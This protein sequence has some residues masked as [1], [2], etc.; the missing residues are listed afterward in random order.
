MP[1]EQVGLQLEAEGADRYLDVLGRIDAAVATVLSGIPPLVKSIN[2]LDDHFR[3]SAKAILVMG[4]A[5]RDVVG[6]TDRLAGAVADAA[7]GVAKIDDVAGAAQRALD[8]LGDAAATA[9]RD[10][11]GLG[12]DAGKAAGGAADLGKKAGAAGK[13][14]G[15]LGDKSRKAGDDNEDLGKK[16]RKG[17]DGLDV[18]GEAAIGATR[19]LGELATEGLQQIAELAVEGFIS[20]AQAAGD[21][22]QSM[23][24]LAAQSE[25]T[26]G[27]MEAVR[28]TAQA[29]GADLTLPGT[30]ALDAGQAMLELSRG[31]L[32]LKDAMDAAKGTLQLA[33]AAETD[34]ATAAGVATGA[35]AAFGLEGG[36][37]GYIADLLTN[38]ANQSRAS[39]GDLALGLQQGQSGFA[40]TGQKVDDLVTSLA[41]LSQNGL[42]GSDAGTA[43]N[44]A[45]QRLINPTDEAAKVMRRYGIEVY[46]AN[47]VML[48]LR[49]IIANLKSG[50]GG[51]TDQ[52][53][54]AALGTIFLTD[55]LKAMAPL[56]KLGAKGF[57]D[58]KAQMNV[59][60]AAARLAGAQMMGLNGAVQ[61]LES[62]I[63]TLT[64]EAFEPLLPVMTDAIRGAAEFAGSLSGDV[65]PA[66]QDL[67]DGGKLVARIV[68][69]AFVPAIAAGTASLIAYG[70]ASASAATANFTLLGPAIGL[71]IQQ[72]TI[73]T[74]AFLAQAAAV[75]LAAAPYVVIAAAIGGIVYV[76]QQVNRT[77][78]EQT[79]ALLNSR[80]WWVESGAALD[81]YAVASDAARTKLEPLATAIQHSRDSIREEL[82]ALG[83]RRTLG[84]LTEQQY[85]AELAVIN[86]HQQALVIQTDRF[87][88]LEQALIAEAAA[89]ATGA[90]VARDAAEAM[91]AQGNVAQLTADDID[92]LTKAIEKNLMAG[93]DAVQKY[94]TTRSEFV[95]GVEQRQSEHA[96]KM[97]ELEAQLAAATTETQKQAIQQ[98]ID[99]AN[100]AYTTQET[101]AAAA[102]AR[103][104]AAQRQH[105]GQMLIDYVVAQAE[106]GNIA[107]D[108]AADL[109]A[110]LEEQ[111]GLQETSVSSTY[112]RMTQAID[113]F[114]NDQSGS[115]DGV[116]GK[117]QEQADAASNTQQKMD[118]YAKEYVSEA[119]NNFAEVT[120]DVNSYVRALEAIPRLVTTRVNTV[121]TSEGRAP[122]GAP[123]RPGGAEAFAR[124]G[125]FPGGAPILVGEEGPEL[126]FPRA[127]GTVL[128][129]Q[130]TAAIMGGG[131]PITDVIGNNSRAA[132]IMGV[133]R[134]RELPASPQQILS[135]STTNYGGTTINIDAR[136]AMMSESQ[137]RAITLDVLSTAG[138]GADGRIR[139]GAP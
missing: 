45:M 20:G 61:G 88:A 124:G 52:Q 57:D 25:A 10:A 31:G 72:A 9:A 6:D 113:A 48:P 29:L 64:L 62:Q 23:N 96:A 108:R 87:K 93:Q 1:L 66:V 51:L 122:Q 26:T 126:I 76:A 21:F 84:Q 106:L 55:G 40:L 67:V 127:P 104:Q 15:G 49:D 7:L 41:L 85:Q 54:N 50:L 78:D 19:R 8:T 125:D 134:S 132:E 63:E 77:L 37:A 81:R 119:V 53:R 46:D 135:A 128:T 44:A 121:Y 83:E 89:N 116:I 136:G 36:Q 47:G 12:Q 18:L 137:Y 105:L 129:A 13:D 80:Q 130:D 95:A 110:A 59:G 38:A 65:G 133:G 131:R 94:A 111:Y 69:G 138:R 16:S 100:A 39:I 123:D 103:Q 28:A 35:L 120:G 4:G 3:L 2:A 30:S 68:E 117:L 86:Q 5:S 33:A 73:A 109:T 91:S 90:G 107:K 101:N 118:A 112:L 56:L 75:A 58:L 74:T 102:Y 97:A 139:T 27:Q 34:V 32:E 42:K 70:I 99:T 82:R 17:A 98:Q 114:A 60:G 71:L 14:V 92:A 115:I 43:L 11:V 24:V 79:D 22:E